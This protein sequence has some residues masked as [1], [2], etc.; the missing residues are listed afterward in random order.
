M[1]DGLAAEAAFKIGKLS[2]Q[3]HCQYGIEDGLT[4]LGQ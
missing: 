4:G 3:R 1:A 2:A